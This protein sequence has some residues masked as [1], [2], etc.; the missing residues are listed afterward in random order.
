[1]QAGPSTEPDLARELI[2]ARVL[3]HRLVALGHWGA[4]MAARVLSSAQASADR[5]EVTGAL[6]VRL[7]QAQAFLDERS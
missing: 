1:M 5:G 7:V 2:R 6:R 4:V 3:S